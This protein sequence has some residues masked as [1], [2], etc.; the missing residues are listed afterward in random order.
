MK[1][2]VLVDE[3]G[4][5]VSYS[6]SGF[7][8]LYSLKGSHWQSI[9]K[10]TLG[11]DN[12]T[13]ISEI[14]DRIHLVMEEIED[15]KVFIVETMKSLPIA[16]FDGYGI[17]VWNHKGIPN[18]AF[19]FVKEQEE[20]KVLKTKS[21][22]DSPRCNSTC[23]PNAG[24]PDSNYSPVAFQNVS[25][26]FYTIN[27]AKVLATDRTLNSKQIL[28]PFFQGI[29][30]QKLEIICDHVP[31]WFEMEF[32]FLN[33]QFETEESKDGLCHAIVHPKE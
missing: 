13:N 8:K 7:L 6:N 31:K 29:A 17:T 11:A 23:S 2:A 1:I 16:I 26:G 15:C 25:E 30:F 10:V 12:G 21:C 33:L 4:N 18:E 5:A 14:R 22:C 19:N 27:L 9:K 32:G 28:I 24:E 3:N 20:N